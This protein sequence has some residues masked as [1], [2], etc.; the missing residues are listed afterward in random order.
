MGLGISDKYI[1]TSINKLKHVWYNTDF[2]L[3]IQEFSF[4]GL[5]SRDKCIDLVTV[6][7]INLFNNTNMQ[8]LSF[9]CQNC[10]VYTSS[11]KDGRGYQ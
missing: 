7:I 4:P 8:N 9:A 1:T 6:C 2:A 10:N 11:R 5:K 3:Y